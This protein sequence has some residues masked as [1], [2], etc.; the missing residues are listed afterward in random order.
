MSGMLAMRVMTTPFMECRTVRSMCT[1]AHVPAP[2][3]AA[4]ASADS[5]VPWP[6]NVVVQGK[7]FVDDEVASLGQ[8]LRGLGGPPVPGI[9]QGLP[10]GL[11]A[12]GQAGHGVVAQGE[13]EAETRHAGILLPAR[14]R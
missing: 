3:R 4:K 14:I 7:G 12:H 10:V 9:E 8:R 11:E 5:T 1:R 2:A 13:P 6:G